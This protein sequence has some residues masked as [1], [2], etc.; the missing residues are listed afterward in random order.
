MRPCL[1][2]LVILI[3][4]VSPLAAAEPDLVETL[5]MWSK[6]DQPLWNVKDV[7]LGAA[8]AAR[9]QECVEAHADRSCF[10]LLI[11]LRRDHQATYDKIQAETKARILIDTLKHTGCADDW[12]WLDSGIVISPKGVVKLMSYDRTAGQALLELPA[13]VTVP[14]LFDVLQQ[15]T[16]ISW[17]GSA[18]ATKSYLDQLRTCDLAFRYL[19]I[20]N[21]IEPTYC[22]ST[23]GR[24][25]AI[26]ALMKKL[27]VKPLRPFEGRKYEPRSF[28]DK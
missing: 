11:V 7:K 10:H 24:D 1:Y 4:N 21:G 9:A 8:E 27:N 28:G 13:K 5:V 17:S 14:T 18:D 23:R 25:Q 22:S 26:Q 2:S 16:E 20:L 12:S 15:E 3:L 19:C 6:R